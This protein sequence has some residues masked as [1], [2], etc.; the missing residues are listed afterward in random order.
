MKIINMVYCVLFYG[1]INSVIRCIS[2]VNCFFDNCLKLSSLSCF[3]EKI[4][5]RV[6]EQSLFT[7][8]CGTIEQEIVPYPNNPLLVNKRHLG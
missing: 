7:Q 2:I 1:F 4:I 3:V 5:K 8:S 6:Q